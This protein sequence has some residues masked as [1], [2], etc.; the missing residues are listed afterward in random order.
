MKILSVLTLTVALLI[1]G[2]ASVDM[3]HG[4][5]RGRKVWD[6]WGGVA[7]E[8][9]RDVGV[10]HRISEVRSRDVG[11]TIIPTLYP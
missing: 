11:S 8:G 2:C 10:G 5:G 7:G 4:M 3:I 1:S 6:L 9:L